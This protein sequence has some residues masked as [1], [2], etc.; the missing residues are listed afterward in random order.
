MN[1]CH[2]L[3]HEEK[4]PRTP[5]LPLEA[6]TS[7]LTLQG[8]FFYIFIS[9]H[10]KFSMIKTSLFL[11][12][13]KIQNKF[14]SLNLTA[15]HLHEQNSSMCSTLQSLY[16]SSH[17]TTVGGIRFLNNVDSSY[18]TAHES[19]PIICGLFVGFSWVSGSI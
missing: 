16:C 7:S 10:S 4:G 8:V 1:I 5:Q 13:I 14:T 11:S 18:P 17:A 3:Q 19:S 2:P 15:S 12:K 6:K 9:F